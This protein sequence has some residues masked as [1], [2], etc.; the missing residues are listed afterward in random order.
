MKGI[1]SFNVTAV[2]W[3]LMMGIMLNVSYVGYLAFWSFPTADFKN[4]P[5]PV[6]NGQ[7]VKPGDVLSYQVDYCRYTSASAD[8]I[9][10]LVGPS[11]ITIVQDTSIT[12]TGCRKIIV[13]NTV[14]PSYAPPGKYHLKITVCYRVNPLRNICHN[15]KTEEFVVSKV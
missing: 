3:L 5:F 11:I 1:R 2:I 9:R 8:V 6:L 13:T 15:L 7:P 4:V 10:T 14:V 12:D